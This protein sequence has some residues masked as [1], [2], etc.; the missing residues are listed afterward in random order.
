MTLKIHLNFFFQI[1][2]TTFHHGNYYLLI[3]YAY[4]CYFYRPAWYHHRHHFAHISEFL[5]TH[6]LGARKMRLWD[7]EAKSETKK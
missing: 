4:L 7:K 3:D 5:Q 6:P 2:S 1:S